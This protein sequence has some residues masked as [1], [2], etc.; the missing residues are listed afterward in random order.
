MKDKIVT[1]TISTIYAT[2]VT[3]LVFVILLG[4]SLGFLLREGIF[5]EDF[6]LS[7]LSV[8]QLYI[9]WN[10]KLELSAKDITFHKTAQQ[11]NSSKF[12][13]EKLDRYLH[14]LA[15]ATHYFN[16]ISIEHFHTH[17]LTATLLFQTNNDGL[18]TV[19]TP[20]WHLHAI[21]SYKEQQL[22][23]TLNKLQSKGEKKISLEGDIV[24]N[25]LHTTLSSKLALNIADALKSDLIIE[26]DKHRLEYKLTHIQ[27]V[28]QLAPIINSFDLPKPVLYW[29]RDAIEMEQVTI[30]QAKGFLEYNKLSEAL[31]NITVKAKADKLL[32]TYNPKLDAIHTSST[33]LEFKGGVLYIYPRDAHSYEMALQKSWLKI[34]FNPKEELLTLHLLF[35]DGMLNKDVLKIL[36]AY[37]IKV[38][39]LQ[40]KGRVDT[41]LTIAVGLRNIGI[42]AHGLFTTRDANFDYLGLN[43]DVAKTTIKLDNYDINIQNMQASY[44]DIAKADVNATYNAKTSHGAITFSLNDLHYENIKLTNKPLKVIYTLDKSGDSITI[45][46]TLWSIDNTHTLSLDAM[47]LPFNLDTLEFEIPTT[48]FT[49]D[50]VASGYITGTYHIKTNEAKLLLDLLHLQYDTIKLNQSVAQLQVL[51]KNNTLSLKAPQ[52]LLFDANGFDMQVDDLSLMVEQSHFALKHTK[53]K[54]NKFF[55]ATLSSH[56]KK[57][58]NTTALRL[59]NLKIYDQSGTRR[60][61]KKSRLIVYVDNNENNLTISSKGLDAR[62]QITP[63]QWIFQANS[64]KKIA[65][66][67]KLLTKLH[68]NNGHFVVSKKSDAKSLRYK[69]E[70]EYPYTLLTL[71]DKAVT[72]YILKGKHNK[73]ITTLNINRVVNAKVHKNEIE[74]D[75]KKA[76]VNIV[77]LYKLTQDIFDTNESS[78]TDMTLNLTALDSFID[79]SNNRRILADSLKLQYFNKIT[80]AQLQYKQGTAGFKLAD[81]TFHLYGKDFNDLFMQNLFKASKFKGGKLDFSVDGTFEKFHGLVYINKTIMVDYKVLNNVLAFVNTV[82]SLVTFSLPGYS[83]EGLAV[84]SAYAQFHSDKGVLDIS[85]FYIDSKEMDIVA[86]GVIDTNKN[87]IDLLMNLKTAIGS[88]ASKIP[89]V[90][91]IIFGK[92]TVSTSLKVTGDLFDPQVSSTLAKDIVVAPLNIIKRTLTLPYELFK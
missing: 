44:Q 87:T 34:D 49:I 14:N 30:S 13:I 27:T 75:I 73:K 10:E 32:Y 54:L 53:I 92:D 59:T 39:F 77:Q 4:I 18:I 58:S 47:Q 65:K 81:N 38:P 11:N 28:T 90:G 21:P 46:K 64:L 61:L 68:L 17:N 66:S 71:N 62:L 31:K 35:D 48:L 84:E 15:L 9:K 37:K 22:H 29:A 16:T 33:D 79:L 42:D 83:K 91:Y 2:I 74:V 55:T 6:T 69:L 86:K 78:Q 67:S 70:L 85:D 36:S 41:D 80:T 76:G 20:Q 72:H 8:K 12:S 3:F 45:P 56:R 23:L 89:V 24:I 60:L 52:T 63:Q 26:A 88:S 1:S 51:Y 43:I 25:T 57:D 40:H 5:V 7:G 50:P 82:P 19:D